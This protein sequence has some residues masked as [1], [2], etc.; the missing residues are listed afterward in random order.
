MAAALELSPA[1]AGIV[2]VEDA[3]VIAIDKLRGIKAVDVSYCATPA[4]T[5][6][7]GR[8]AA[9]LF[10]HAR[11]SWGFFSRLP[12]L[13]GASHVVDMRAKCANGAFSPGRK[14]PADPLNPVCLGGGVP[15]S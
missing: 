6:R 7:I 15:G 11:D 8:I 12:N 10:A 3:R 9:G 14:S 2:N 4:L 5:R 13:E 1:M